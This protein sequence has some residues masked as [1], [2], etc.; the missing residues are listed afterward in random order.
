M[1]ITAQNDHPLLP[2]IATSSRGTGKKPDNGQLLQGIKGSLILLPFDY[3]AS[4]SITNLAR[5]ESVRTHCSDEVRRSWSSQISDQ[6]IHWYK[7][8]FGSFKFLKK[9]KITVSSWWSLGMPSLVQV[10][11]AVCV[12]GYHGAAVSGWQCFKTVLPI[13]QPLGSVCPVFWMSPMLGD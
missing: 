13:H 10:S 4:A 8:I 12:L 6:N 3:H 5:T 9:F 11:V 2:K 7:L 1:M